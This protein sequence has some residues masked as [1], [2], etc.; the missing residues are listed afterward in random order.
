MKSILQK[1]KNIILVVL[2]FVSLFL[3][4]FR[5]TTIPKVWVDEGIF[6]NIAETVTN[7]GVFGMQTSLNAT[8]RLGPLAS[9]NYPVIFPVAL[10]LKIFSNGIWQSRLPMVIYMLLLVIFLYFSV[11]EKY[12]FYH[13]VSSVLLLISFAPFYGNGRSVI[14]EVP[15]LAFIMLGSWMLSKFE[16]S[17]F[18]NKKFAILSGLFLGLAAASKSL[19]LLIFTVGVPLVL[20]F[21]W[22]KISN[23]KNLF[24]LLLTFFIP[25]VFWFIINC[26]TLEFLKQFVPS[27]VKQAGNNGASSLSGT[28][29]STLGTIWVNFKR[30]FTES[31]PVLFSFVSLFVLSFLALRYFKKDSEKF[32]LT[33]ILIFFAIGSNWIGYLLGTGWYR[34]FF[35]AQVLLFFFFP[36][37]ISACSSLFKKEILRKSILSIPIL[38]ILFQ[39]TYLIFFSDTS[40]VHRLARNNELSKTLSIIPASKKV[41]FYNVPEAVVFLKGTNYSQY[42]LMPGLFEAGNINAMNDVSNDYIL[43]SEDVDIKK[44]NMI[45]FCYEQIK[46]DRYFFFK[47]ISNNPCRNRRA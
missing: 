10:S 46:V 27:I 13:A 32:S 36:A 11:K 30:F 37:S 7:K 21:N 33:E 42:L 6:T 26:P 39:F 43:S 9:V 29:L 41:L 3:I 1:R 45:P 22:R 17:N 38:L 5:Y 40:L 25:I 44:I 2:F 28:S 12:G 20:F 18:E 19:Y 8:F 31:T 15:G 16:S 34:Y 24:F 35:P 14:G 47:K 23:K 4:L